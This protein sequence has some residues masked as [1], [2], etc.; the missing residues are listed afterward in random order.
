MQ[1]FKPKRAL[2]SVSD[3]NGLL[4]LAQAL[5]AQGVEIVATG[6]TAA[7][8]EKAGFAVTEVSVCTGF[9]EIL[10]GRVKTLHPKIHAGLLARGSRD[11]ETLE[12]L[13][14]Q[15]F[16][17]LIVNLYPFEQVTKGHHQF[18]DAI[19]NID[20][21][22]PAMIRAAAKNFEQVLPIVDTDDYAGLVDCL[23]QGQMPD[24]LRL[25][26]ARKAF[27]LTAAYD[28]AIAKYLGHEVGQPLRYGENPHQK[29]VFHLD[30]TPKEGSLA[31]AKM[32]QGK[33]LSYNNL[34]DADAAYNCIRAFPSD[35][36]TTVIIKHGNPC[37]IA[38]GETLVQAYLRAYHCD[39]QSSYGGILGLNQ[40]IDAETAETIIKTQF[41]EVVLAPF[42]SEE[43]K[44][45]FL[46]KPNIRVLITGEMP[47]E[48]GAW[49]RKSINGGLLT[50]EV[51]NNLYKRFDSEQ[52]KIVSKKA[53]SE[54][55]K[56]ELLFAW[57]AVKHVKS[58]AIVLAKDGATIGIGAGQTSRVMSTRIALWQAQDSKISCDGAVMASDAFIP[59]KDSLEMAIEAGIR[60][61][62]QPGGSIRDDEIIRIADEAGICMVF[63]GVRHFRH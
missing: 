20:I 39:P 53:P 62:I 51:D 34:L 59:F 55:Q 15:A 61:V 36:P 26:L 46:Q 54:A 31:H 27:A 4:P 38:Q 6:N 7:L 41:A 30:P 40:K 9:P 18:N 2:V 3:K 10:D 49:E 32:L 21:G 25:E 24:G 12:A 35:Q 22:G 50:Q 16:D 5:R 13:G 33:S 37:G 45:I 47:E 17:L 42:I 29:A 43:A 14:I 48:T 56:K 23:N 11:Q 1:A 57:I 28:A 44:A 63:T 52:F 58:N 60:A 8:L 19:E